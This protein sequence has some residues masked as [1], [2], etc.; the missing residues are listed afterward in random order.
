MRTNTGIK[1]GIEKDI[2]KDL[3]KGDLLYSAVYD[4]GSGRTENEVFMFEEYVKAPSNSKGVWA[5]Y[6]EVTHMS[7]DGSDI[8]LAM[9]DHK[10]EDGSVTKEPDW[11]VNDVSVGL[12]L[13]PVDALK[14][15]ER[16]AFSIYSSAKRAT[17][18]AEDAAKKN[19]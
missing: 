18:A 1:S 14:A 6:V 4:N 3:K 19:K 2:M 11:R 5:K 9:K 12:F 13:N 17:K 8:E 10:N 16:V 15:W 7:T